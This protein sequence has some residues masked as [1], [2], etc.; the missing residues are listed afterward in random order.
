LR[1]LGEKSSR[2]SI[3]QLE[4]AVIINPGSGIVSDPRV[5]KE[6]AD[7]YAEE[8]YQDILAEY[9]EVEFRRDKTYDM[10]DG[11]WAYH[12]YHPVTG[13]ENQLCAVGLT[14][15]EI[16]SYTFKPRDWWAG[17]SLWSLKPENW[18]PDDGSYDFTYRFHKKVAENTGAGQLSSHKSV[19]TH[20]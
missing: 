2:S 8:F 11:R 17:E 14:K 10:G 1:L 5:S 7:A 15:E 4:M 16:Q 18:I 6:K 20:K 9:P 3:K 19:T 12:F 13:V